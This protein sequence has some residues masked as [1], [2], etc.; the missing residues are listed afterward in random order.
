MSG[1]LICLPVSHS[2]SGFAFKFIMNKKISSQLFI[3]IIC[4]C[5]LSIATS[6]GQS[7]V[8]GRP[9]SVLPNEGRPRMEKYKAPPYPKLPYLNREP[10]DYPKL[11][12]KSVPATL[13]DV[14]I[15]DIGQRLT[16]DL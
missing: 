16:L 15:C 2:S 12:K 11:S 6:F 1:Y 4:A 7:T 10:Y 5:W 14:F 3:I 9:A 13:T 8:P